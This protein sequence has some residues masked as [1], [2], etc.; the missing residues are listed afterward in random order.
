MVAFAIYGVTIYISF[1]YETLSIG[2]IGIAVTY[3]LQMARTLMMFTYFQTELELSLNAVERIK[4]YDDLPQEAAYT[5]LEMGKPELSIEQWP[6]DGR[7]N[8]QNLWVK[9]RPELDDTLKGVSLVIPAKAKVGVCGRTGSGKS[10]LSLA[11]FRILEA[12]KGSI[13]I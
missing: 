5:E 7:I 13:Q 11:L 12:S 9:Y 4:V 6:K 2:Y 3:C 8:I 10:T 1:M